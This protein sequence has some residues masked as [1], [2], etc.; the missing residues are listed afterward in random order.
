MKNI[1]SKRIHNIL[2]DAYERSL[3]EPN[4]NETECIE[5]IVKQFAKYLSQ[6]PRL[7]NARTNIETM[8]KDRLLQFQVIQKETLEELEAFMLLIINYQNKI[9][10]LSNVISKYNQIKIT[11]SKNPD[12]MII[13]LY[14]L[15]TEASNMI[16]RTLRWDLSNDHN[17]ILQQLMVSNSK[18]TILL[19]QLFIKPDNNNNDIN[20][21]EFKFRLVFFKYTNEHIAY[22]TFKQTGIFGSFNF[23]SNLYLF[24][25]DTTTKKENNTTPKL[26][27]RLCRFHMNIVW[28]FISPLLLSQNDDVIPSENI[29]YDRL[30]GYLTIKH[31]NSIYSIKF[32]RN[33]LRGKIL[34]V[35]FPGGK[36]RKESIS[37]A[38]IYDE[39]KQQKDHSVW[40]EFDCLYFDDLDSDNTDDGE[41]ET[42]PNQEKIKRSIRDSIDGKNAINDRITEQT[43][44]EKIIFIDFL[45]IFIRCS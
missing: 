33:T 2:K 37:F 35:L 18:N 28:Q 36:P 5:I 31:N 44:L 10:V 22:E 42:N 25:V 3:N 11:C 34:E 7:H 27:I 23:I 16:I 6:H 45:N 30:T 17:D 12:L 32:G 14:E 4:G 20:D 24:N 41:N 9:P 40:H 8:G 38:E 15:L 43:Q 19:S 29:S 13:R 39:I 1:E 21:I 26:D